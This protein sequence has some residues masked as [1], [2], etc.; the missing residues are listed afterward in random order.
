MLLLLS[1]PLL[2][3]SQHDSLVISG[4]YYFPKEKLAPIAAYLAQRLDRPVAIHSAGKLEELNAGIT[5]GSIDVA[6]LNP[7]SYVLSHAETGGGI[8]PLVM[9]S[10]ADGNPSFYRSMLVS[11]ALGPKS[12]EELTKVSDQQTITFVHATSTSGHL[13]PRLHFAQA[14]LDPLEMHF[15]EVRFA[16][17]HQEAIAEL[18][19]G[20]ASLIACSEP[21][22]R[23][24]IEKGVLAEGS[25]NLLWQSDPIPEP[26]VAVRSGLDADVKDALE[27]AFVEM[28]N[29]PQAPWNHVVENFGSTHAQGFVPAL[30]SYYDP[31]REMADSMEQLILFLTFYME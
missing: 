19:R 10:D 22:L 21:D 20:E 16:G 14:G 6:F 25:F 26:L 9:M 3:K 1:F 17:G 11:A 23:L 13:I 27:L 15:A 18:A 31:I 12:F 24:A 28:R 30:D 29:T 7:F 8:E 5:D 4:S 2:G